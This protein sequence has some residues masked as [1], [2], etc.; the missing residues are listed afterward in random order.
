MKTMSV[1][2]KNKKVLFIALLA[3][4]VIITGAF[5]GTLARYT[6]SESVS[7]DADVAKFGL[8]VPNTI[9]LFSESY[10]NVESDTEGKNVIAPGTEGSYEFEVT[11]SSEVAYKVS[12]S[13]DVTYSEEWGGYYPLEFSVDGIEWTNVGDFETNFAAS[14][15]SETMAPNQ[16]YSGEH[17]IYWR[18][19]F[20]VS[21]A[22][23]LKDTQ[24]GNL[25]AAG[26]APNVTVVI[27]L[28]AVQVD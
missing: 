23:D 28:S 9:D 6:T 12:G 5:I 11:G 3:L 26:N 13:V 1:K 18:W 10:T 21:A 16:P 27:E 19:P 22:F 8:N 14:F 7:E 2:K 4:L 17:T 20:T 15:S 25:A 24:M